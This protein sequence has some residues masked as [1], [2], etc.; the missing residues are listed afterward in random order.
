MAIGMAKLF[1]FNLRQNFA[2]P[3]FSRDIAE[4]WRRWH[5]S[6]TT[7]FRDYVYIPLGG[8][9]QGKWKTILNVCI[10]FVVSGFWHGAQWH[11]VFWGALNGLLFLP[12][13]I[14][15]RHRSH[16]DL[17]ATNKWLPSI[18]ELAKMISTFIL[19][20]LTFIF[21]RAEN[22]T[23]AFDYLKRMISLDIFTLPQL[24]TPKTT[25]VYC[26]ILLLPLFVVEW[27]HR[28]RP[29]GLE[30]AYLSKP[31]RWVIYITIILS[32]SVFGYFGE[33]EFIYFQ[34]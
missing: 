9:R 32:I 30:I 3:L 11:Y 34:F 4:F 10:V 24:L 8:S 1:G 15:N 28:E 16:M 33:N 18:R 19:M 26:L 12:L 17:V 6:L 27:I 5:I 25:M 7:W 2:F 13:M 22:L 14:T 21:F 29:H 31:V 20:A 23:H